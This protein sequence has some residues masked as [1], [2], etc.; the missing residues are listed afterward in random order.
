VSRLIRAQKLEVRRVK[1]A[2]YEETKSMVTKEASRLQNLIM[3]EFESFE[4]QYN[5][6]RKEYL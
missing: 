3:D 4:K 2:C 1:R 5:K 6:L